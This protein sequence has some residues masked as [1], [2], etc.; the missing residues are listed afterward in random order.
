M[1]MSPQEVAQRFPDHPEARRVSQIAGT[2]AKPKTTLPKGPSWLEAKFQMDVKAMK[3]PAP[4]AEHVFHPD[5]RWRF[6]FAW[7]DRKLAVEIEGGVL[8]RGRHVRPKGFQNDCEKYNAA[9][10][11]GWTVLRFTGADVK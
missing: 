4:K 10:N 3:L 2:K 9:A 5:R 8:S 11:L 6:D 7:I 1:R